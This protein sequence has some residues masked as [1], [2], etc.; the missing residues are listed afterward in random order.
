[1]LCLPA[2]PGTLTV[3]LNLCGKASNIWEQEKGMLKELRPLN[4]QI[5]KN[6]WL[7]AFLLYEIISPL[8]FKLFF[9]CSQKPSDLTHYVY[10]STCLINSVS[11]KHCY[12]YTFLSSLQHSLVRNP[13]LQLAQICRVPVNKS[14][15]D[16]NYEAYNQHIR[17]LPSIRH[18]PK[19]L[20]I[21]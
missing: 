2:L 21:H 4:Y 8:P 19:K 12:L 11:P 9:S 7:P 16:D 5:L 3:T 1:M 10:I 13:D 20:Y 6:A 18:R 14:K 15:D 17:H